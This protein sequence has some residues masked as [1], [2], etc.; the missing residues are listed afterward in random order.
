MDGHDFFSFTK[1]ERRGILTFFVVMCILFVSAQFIKVKLKHPPQML[2]DY[3]VPPPEIAKSDSF[4]DGKDSPFWDESHEFEPK[5]SRKVFSFDPN[6]LGSDSLTLLG[7]NKF[8]IKNLI[9]YRSKGGKFTNLS[10]LKS[11]Y[12]IDTNLVNELEPYIFFPDVPNQFKKDNQVSIESKVIPEKKTIIVE[13][14]L[15]DSTQLE[16]I[17]GISPYTASKIISIRDRLGGFLYKEQL[18]ELNIVKDSIFQLFADQLSVNKDNIVK[19]NINTADYRTFTKH[20]YFTPQTANAILKYRK[21]HGD[22]STPN[23]IRK[24]ISIKEEVG[25]KILPYLKAN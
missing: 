3:Y 20:P 19:I 9:N 16:A 2:K 22:F 7:F 8:A 10:K 21:Q 13:L 17:K 6:K 25:M 23:D 15:A 18:T 4:I 1:Q 14:N 24:I 5:L 11:I 12:G